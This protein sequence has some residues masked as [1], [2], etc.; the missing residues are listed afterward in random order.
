[1]ENH[2]MPGIIDNVYFIL[3]FLTNHI[4]LQLP[5]VNCEQMVSRLDDVPRE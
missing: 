2:M 1:M 5:Q 3:D 4:I